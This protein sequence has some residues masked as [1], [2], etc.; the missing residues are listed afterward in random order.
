MLGN[1]FIFLEKKNFILFK[2]E[3][4]VLTKYLDPQ[5]KN[6]HLVDVHSF[7]ILKQMS[8]KYLGLGMRIEFCPFPN[9]LKCFKL[10][11]KVLAEVISLYC[12]HLN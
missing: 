9:T 11:N 7:K 5:K 1:A 8:F 10:E 4:C 2:I 12:I 6:V 3:Y